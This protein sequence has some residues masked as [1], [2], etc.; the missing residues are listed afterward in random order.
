MTFQR[1]KFSMPFCHFSINFVELYLQSIIMLS[2]IYIL[3]LLLPLFV[4]KTLHYSNHF[5]NSFISISNDFQK[6][7]L[8]SYSFQYL[9]I[10]FIVNLTIKTCKK[11][12]I[13]L[14]NTQ[15]TKLRI[16]ST[17]HFSRLP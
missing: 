10:S 15:L 13:T 4:P 11:L 14:K 5:Q 7:S 12:C 1:Y 9:I 2:F 6:N 17:I 3:L 8:L 16:C